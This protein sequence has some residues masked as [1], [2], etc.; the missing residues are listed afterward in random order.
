[1]TALQ[2]SLKNCL[3][4]WWSFT[5]RWWLGFWIVDYAINSSERLLGVSLN[6]FSNQL[7]SFCEAGFVVFICLKITLQ[8]KY[9]RFSI[10][11]LPLDNA[12]N[13]SELN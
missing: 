10:A 5:W 12:P 8:K 2:F 11:L 6:Q 9:A 13:N 3:A 7:I 1:M 4:I